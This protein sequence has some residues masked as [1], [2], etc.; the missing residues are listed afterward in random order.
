MKNTTTINLFAVDTNKNSQSPCILFMY[1]DACGGV[2]FVVVFQ[3]HGKRSNGQTPPR[4]FFWGYECNSREPCSRWFLFY[5]LCQ[6]II[7]SHV[8]QLFF[9]QSNYSANDLSFAI[10]IKR[11]A[12]VWWKLPFFIRIIPIK[13][14]L[15]LRIFGSKSLLISTFFSS[16]FSHVFLFGHCFYLQKRAFAFIT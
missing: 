13:L 8:F 6:K 7:M 10:C 9:A 3:F 15:F 5:C 2:I 14:L 1:C 11:M 12:K 4:W 16:S